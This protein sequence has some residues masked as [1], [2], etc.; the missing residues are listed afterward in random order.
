MAD[1]TKRPVFLS[2]MPADRRQRQ[3]A[4]TVVLLSL[5]IF[6]AAVPFARLQ[7]PEVWAF[8]PIY[9][10]TLAIN[11]LITA[12]LLFVQFSILRTRAL[13]ALACGFLFTAVMVVPHALTFPGLFSSTGLLGAGPQT[14]AWLYMFWHGVFPLLVMFYAMLKAADR[15]TEQPRG[16]IRAIIFS[17]WL[18]FWHSPAG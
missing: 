9:E 15:D 5:L 7:L 13:L 10:S 4:L 11:D 17:A 8:I 16:S 6:I 14:T 12:S 3:F 2:T 1:E 18:P